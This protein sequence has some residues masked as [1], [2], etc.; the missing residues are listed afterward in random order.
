ME[1]VFF[2]CVSFVWFSSPRSHLRSLALALRNATFSPNILQNALQ[3]GNNVNGE[4]ETDAVKGEMRGTCPSCQKPVTTEMPRLSVE[5]V[6]YHQEC[7]EV[8]TKALQ[9]V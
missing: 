8:M 5:G 3:L 4:V 9:T 1:P 7:H 2:S 6:Y